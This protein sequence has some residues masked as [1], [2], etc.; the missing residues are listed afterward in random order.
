MLP[1][2]ERLKEKYLFKVA[3]K[4]R[5]KL[6]LTFLSLYYLFR[7]NDIN[8]STLPKCAFIVGLGVDKRATKRNLVK[9][10]MRAAYVMIKKKF[11]LK[12]VSVLIW[13]AHPPIASATFEQVN[14]SMERL[15][16]KL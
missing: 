15:L 9:R 10:R 1:K 6:G 4:K 7:K 13:I 5:Q 11:D 14:D 3:F 8:K 2:R 16:N 12:R